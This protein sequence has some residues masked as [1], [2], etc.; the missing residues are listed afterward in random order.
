MSPRSPLRRVAFAAIPSILCALVLWSAYAFV[1]SDERAEQLGKELN[2]TAWERSYIERSLAV[3]ASGIETTYFHLLGR[4]LEAA[5]LP[6]RIDVFTAG[7]WKAVQEVRA[8]RLHIAEYRRTSSSCW[9]A[10]TT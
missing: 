6:T 10:S 2:C 9:M 1:M 3:P 7:A 5:N 4:G 8:L